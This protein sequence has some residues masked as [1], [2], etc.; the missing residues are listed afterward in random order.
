M[1]VKFSLHI[2]ITLSEKWKFNFCMCAK[3]DFLGFILSEIHFN[4]SD[5]IFSRWYC[6]YSA[7]YMLK[8]TPSYTLFLLFGFVFCLSVS[9]FSHIKEI[10]KKGKCQRWIAQVLNF[11]G[12]PCHWESGFSFRGVSQWISQWHFTTAMTFLGPA[13][14]MMAFGLSQTLILFLPA[15]ISFLD[16]KFL[17]W[18]KSIMQRE[19]SGS[20]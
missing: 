12:T 11:S 19:Q 10:D 15:C 14:G 2:P 16:E 4:Y 6:C 13:S 18:Q 9:V 8:L 5:P 20:K 17:F 7:V 1:K 3:D